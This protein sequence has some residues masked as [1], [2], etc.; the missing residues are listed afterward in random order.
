MKQREESTHS[1]EYLREIKT[2][3]KNILVY[4]S[5]AKGQMIDEK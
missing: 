1:G 4:L 5:E 2:K 3:Y